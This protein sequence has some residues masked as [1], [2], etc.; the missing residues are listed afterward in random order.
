MSWICAGLVH[1]VTIP[2]SS[3]VHLLCSVVLFNSSLSTH[4]GKSHFVVLIFISLLTGDV[5]TFSYPSIYG[6][7]LSLFKSDYLGVFVCLLFAIE[8][9]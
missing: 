8:L 5:D 2:V 1:A 9:C 7:L 3:Y 6:A 4:L